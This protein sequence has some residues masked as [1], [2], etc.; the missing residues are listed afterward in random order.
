MG[1]GVQAAEYSIGN[2]SNAEQLQLELINRARANPT[3][4]GVRLEVL[5]DCY[6][7]GE[8]EFQNVNLALMKSEFAAIAVAPPLSFNVNLNAAAK[9]H[10]Q[11]MLN[12]GFQG[13]TSSPSAPWPGASSGDRAD[14]HG[15]AGWSGLSENV[16]SYAQ[17]PEHTHASFQ[18]DWGPGT[19]GMQIGRPHRTNIHNPAWTEVGIGM[20]E[21]ENGEYGPGFYTQ[22]F[23]SRSAQATFVTG[24]V[25][26][27]SNED[28]FYDMGE[29]VGG[30]RVEIAGVTDYAVTSA[31][32]GYSIPVSA[33]G[34]YTVSFLVNGMVKHTE[35]VTIASGESVKLD[36]I[37]P[38]TQPQLSGPSG[39]PL[40]TVVDFYFAEVDAADSYEVKIA[41][42]VPSPATEGAESGSGEISVDTSPGYNVIQ[43]L[44]KHSG[45]SAFHLTHPSLN[46]PDQWITLDRFFVPRSGGELKFRSRFQ[47]GDT[48]QWAKVL[49]SEDEGITWTPVWHQ[50]G[51]WPY[52]E[53][54]TFSLKTVSL[55]DYAGDHIQVRFQF[56]STTGYMAVGT[57]TAWGWFVDDIE[58]TDVDE[59]VDESNPTVAPGSKL[60][61]F[62]PDDPGT[63]HLYIR[64]L[65]EG[66]HLPW[67][68]S[69]VLIVG[70]N[71]YAGWADRM[72]TLAGLAKGTLSDPAGDYD[73]DG[74]T[75]ALEYAL[76][77]EGF[78]PVTTENGMHTAPQQFSGKIGY[79]FNVDDGREDVEL[80]AKAST[81]LVNWYCE[82]QTGAPA[83]FETV[84]VSG[85]AGSVSRYRA[86]VDDTADLVFFKIEATVFEE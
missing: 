45:S 77:S 52:P 20:V 71:S 11:D 42:L 37:P 34:T 64:A 10:S 75:Q 9:G 3:A 85:G 8:Y 29:G 79:D 50:R 68:D 62:S 51:N 48:G 74:Y 78:S 12:D 5:D 72:E 18:V 61:S 46:A 31:S 81:D 69:H 59:L 7:I 53:E 22:D 47:R 28:A 49:I 33:D 27:D 16:Y 55:D 1:F 26:Y 17:T 60:F 38:Y 39:A 6:T 13:H 44:K 57:S 14:N 19:G 76:E 58:F 35:S 82:G 73:G 21:G 67:S 4:E 15:Y 83:G 86:Q 70:E 40:E 41:T 80:V 54:S 30:V 56:T 25:F 84:Y 63:L 36:W 65:T 24:V 32:G 2:P 66:G 43:S 23:S